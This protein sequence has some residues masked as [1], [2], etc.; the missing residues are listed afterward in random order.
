[1]REPPPERARGL[2]ALLGI[3]QI[4]LR[5]PLNLT[6]RLVLVLAAGFIATAMVFP[7][8]KIRLVAP[9][10]RD[11][12]EL[13]IYTWKLEA[14]NGG[15][16][17]VE[18]NLLN[19]YIGMKPLVQ[20]EFLEMQ[21]M[22]FAFGLLILLILRAAVLGR[23]VAVVDLVVVFGYFG[24]FSIG[25]FAYRLYT[26]GHNLDTMAPVK[27]E[28]FMPMLIGVSKIANF[29]QSSF[30]QT[31]AILLFASWVLLLAAAFFSRREE[32]L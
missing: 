9:Q 27:I 32:A 18:I 3:E 13:S 2:R 7:V 23:M 10:Y 4:F 17:L 20:A 21:W 25:T 14:G 31:G 19:H 8:W 26:Y 5:K 22:P 30:P 1:M 6:S 12:L 15:Q 24:A 16:D 11:G 29:T 28:P